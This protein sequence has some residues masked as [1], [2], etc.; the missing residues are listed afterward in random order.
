M[1]EDI[2]FNE[3]TE[4][5]LEFLKDKIDQKYT[6][7]PSFLKFGEPF[8]KSGKQGLLGTLKVKTKEGKKEI[9]YKL[10]QYLN[11][12]VE[13]ENLM[14]KGL[15]EIRDYCPH[16]CKGFG[17]ITIPV[18]PEFRKKENPFEC[19]DRHK[20]YTDVLLMESLYPARKLYR[21]LKKNEFEEEILYSLIKQSLLAIS[22]AQS[23]KHF[24]HYD[25]HSN[26]ILVK[27]CPKNSCFL[28]IL[29]DDHQYLV[30]TY[31]YYPI[32]IDYG[33]GYISEMENQPI[34]K[35][36]D[37]TDVGFM[38]DRFDQVAD[39]KL[40]L[41]TISDEIKRYRNSKKSKIFR[42][43]V[44][45]IFKPLK[46]DY[47]TGWD[48]TED[49]GATDYV[50][51]LLEEAE[52]KSKST[53][54][55]EYSNYLLGLCQKL[56]TLPLKKQSYKK[57]DKMYSLIIEEFKKIEREISSD[58]YNLYIFKNIIDITLEVKDDYLSTGRREMA[59]LNF[60]NK[61]LDVISSCAKFC[62]P[63]VDF[64]TLLC[65]LLIFARQMEGVL[66]EVIEERMLEK[67]KEYRKMKITSTNEIFE[68]IETNLPSDFKIDEE[69]IIYVF[70]CIKETS[71][72]TK[73]PEKYLLE[74]NKQHTLFR[75][76]F[77]FDI[78]KKV[79]SSKDEEVSSQMDSKQ[80]I[81]SDESENEITKEVLE[82]ED[83]KELLKLEQ[84]EDTETQN[85]SESDEV[86]DQIDSE[87]YDI[88]KKDSDF[89][90]SDE[91]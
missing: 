81:N 41:I 36:L 50:L 1:N 88:N 18:D 15:N 70:D 8:T 74:L 66:Y 24:A 77:I 62:L 30:P 59:V 48:E 84:D 10:S 39:P 53:F 37:H 79:I 47:E 43:L 4:Y 85:E 82:D 51:S 5:L 86:T 87:D 38:S 72:K 52:H 12:L 3:D 23:K 64:E 33:F 78:Y 68:A 42:N 6:S 49:L 71:F 32:I 76:E 45:N 46:I 34:S 26:N 16:F 40:F 80:N 55:K 65:S 73:V 7:F 25:L 44:K 60:K 28:Y 22:I 58:F 19:E 21:Y 67:R 2:L 56:I 57:I 9:V 91:D 29:D 69:T 27:K 13:G 31:G 35:S 75:G 90:F 89:D 83:E 20:I 11:F 61:I 54:F 17:K 63:K 14:M